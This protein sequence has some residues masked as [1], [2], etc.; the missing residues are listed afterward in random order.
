ML[1]ILSAKLTRPIVPPGVIDRP[2]LYGQLDRWQGVR[3]IAVHAPAG[4]GKSTLA[5]RWIDRADLGAQT[6][7][8]SLSED[9]RQARQFAQ[10]LAAALD[11]LLPGVLAAVEPALRDREGSAEPA[12][13]RLLAVLEQSLTARP[14][15]HF[16]VVLDDLQYVSTPPLDA[17]V[18]QLLEQGP[19]N[20]HFLLLSRSLSDTLPLARLVARGELLVL[21]KGDLRFTQD[22]VWAYLQGHGFLRATPTDI[23]DLTARS[24][25]WVSA[26]Q[27]A[28][29]ATPQ[30]D[31]VAGLRRGLR[32]DRDWLARYLADEVID[33]QRPE[34]SL[35]L[36]QISLL[37]QFNGSLCVAVTGRDDAA[38]LLAEAVGADLFLIALEDGW[39]R[40]HH[41]FQQSLRRRLSESCSESEVAH[42]HRR[43]AGWL[44]DRG[45]NER[46]IA[47][48]L[49]AGAED[50]A[51]VLLEQQLHHL[52]INNPFAADQLIKRTLPAFRQSW[53]EIE[54]FRGLLTLSLDGSELHAQIEQARARV[55]ELL[56]KPDTQPATAGRWLVLLGTLEYTAGEREMARQTLTRAATFLD[57]LDDLSMGHY[58]FIEAHFHR[59]A[60]RPLEARRTAADALVAYHAADF[61]IGAVAVQRELARWTQALGDR[62]E[63]TR[64]F[65]VLLEPSYRE[66]PE[67]TGELFTAA[68]CAAENCY[69]QADLPGAR[70]Y[71]QSAL[72]WADELARE[73]M[74]HLAGSMAGLYGTAGA[75]TDPLTVLPERY[76]ELFPWRGVLRL[77]IDMDTR[78]LIAAG[79][80]QDAWLLAQ[81]L[82]IDPAI[83]SAPW[84][85]AGLTSYL[86]A[87]VASEQ[88]VELWEPLLLS[89][90]AGHQGAGNRFFE[91]QLLSLSVWHQ[92][93]T[94]DP[95][96]ATSLPGAANLAAETG[97][98]MPLLEIPGLADAWPDLAVEWALPELALAPAGQV[99]LLTSREQQIL[100]L[101]AV[102][103][104]Y[105]QMSD[106]L[107]ISINTVRTHVRNLY[108]KLGV[109]RR[110]QALEAARQLGLLAGR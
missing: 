24:E 28:V 60:D 17:F 50:E 44:A 87:A 74:S 101:L 20:L 81:Q 85:H 72:G 25:G 55:G 59:I 14:D 21:D 109:G 35:F 23:E 107:M 12:Q 45:R 58:W 69:W 11:A 71:Q 95:N 43:A 110:A 54:Y 10:L 104:T 19:R 15:D 62:E 93:R 67:V 100:T 31:D 32:G 56:D 105:E 79:R 83:G 53:P 77:V 29:L 34:M 22:E 84:R 63:A 52:V 5:S 97:Y 92:W 64:R 39:Y 98:V 102:D 30:A 61:L 89:A 68:F 42:L 80:Y 96:L 8:L 108:K 27:L 76:K 90:I 7:W 9:E 2:R 82:D 36:R 3:A 47:H 4:Y 66:R 41:L 46:A 73:W 37:E 91:L 49:A 51:A 13:R 65:A 103:C 78:R 38:A 18:Y 33:R 88:A 57:D 16:L 86:R 106:E 48:W 70:A 26:L 99:D 40:Y 6:A 94:G 75:T 1:M